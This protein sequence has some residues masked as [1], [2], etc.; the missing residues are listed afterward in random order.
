MAKW[1]LPPSGGHMDK[2]TGIYFQTMTA[3]DVAER[4]KKNDI[5]I[6]PSDPLKT[7]VRQAHSAKTPS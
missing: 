5:L 4:L 7:T 6:V 1:N 2:P 3:K